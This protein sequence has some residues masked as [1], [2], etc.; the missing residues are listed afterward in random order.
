MASE[1]L[2]GNSAVSKPVTCGPH[3]AKWDKS[4]W[5]WPWGG[6]SV[7]V[8]GCTPWDLLVL[9]D[10]AVMALMCWSRGRPARKNFNGACHQRKMLCVSLQRPR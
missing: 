6:S 8:A 9:T 5:T 10:H 2:L 3:V 4:P 7:P 1:L